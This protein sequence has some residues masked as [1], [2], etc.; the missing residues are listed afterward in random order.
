MRTIKLYSVSDDRV[1]YEFDPVTDGSEL[2]SWATTSK[3]GV[4]GFGDRRL[5]GLHRKETIFAAIYAQDNAL[6]VALPPQHF[7]WPGAFR[8]RRRSW[9]SRVK[10]FDIGTESRRYVSFFYT[11]LDS[12][13]EFPGPEA[14]DIFLMIA[15]KTSSM[16]MIQNT[17]HQWQEMALTTETRVKADG[18]GNKR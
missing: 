2:I 17:I 12:Q 6:H 18:V 4:C 7:T 9:L 14:M 1:G 16:E 13:H 3:T 10:S 5:V 8:A 15:W 11:F